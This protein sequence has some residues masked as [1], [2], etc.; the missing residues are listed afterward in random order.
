MADKAEKQ[1]VLAIFPDEAAADK[2]VDGLKAWA[3]EFTYINLTSIGV[4][5]LD[6]NGKL[7]D[8]KMGS[9]SISK[10]VGIGILLAIV[11]PPTLL[12][13]AV[14]GG[15]IGALHHKGLGM[16]SA[17][18]ARIAGE[19]LGG[20]AAIGVLSNTVDAPVLMEQLIQLGGAAEVLAVTPEAMAELDATAEA[21]AATA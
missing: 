15:V 4:L 12:A 5:V 8:H 16:S 19:L 7:K 2:A 17:E 11:A 6:G 21:G 10:G 18:Q 13:G 3:E 20:K 14:G 1:V 9:R